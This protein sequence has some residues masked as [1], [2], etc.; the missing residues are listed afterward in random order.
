MPVNGWPGNAERVGNLLHRVAASVVHGSCLGNLG[1]RHLELSPTLT[2]AC[3]CGGKTIMG[4]FDDQIMFELC[5]GCE[6]ME[7][8]PAAGC[9]RIDPLRQCAQTDAA[10]LKFLGDLLQ[11]PDRTTQPIQLRHNQGVALTD[12]LKHLVK[13]RTPRK[14]A[15]GVVNKDFLA[16]GSL[17]DVRLRFRVLIPCGHPRISDQSHAQM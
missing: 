5:D 16:P 12:I 14:C 8:E 4:S 11:I 10:L 17:Q 1:C 6:H 2:T 9:C 7:E 15:G 3:A 13:S